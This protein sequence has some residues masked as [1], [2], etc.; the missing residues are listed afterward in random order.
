MFDLISAKR[1]HI[2]AM[3]CPASQ[4]GF[5][6]RS[7]VTIWTFGLLVLFLLA[8]GCATGPKLKPLVDSTQRF[9]GMG[10]SVLPPRG[11][12][13]FI[14][15]ASEYG[16]SFL[17]SLHS[18]DLPDRGWRT[19]SLNLLVMNP[20]H[21]TSV[22]EAHQFPTALEEL[23]TA[24]FTGG[25]FRLIEVKTRPFGDRLN[26]CSEYDFVQQEKHNPRAPEVVLAIRAHGF[27]CFDQSGEFLLNAQVS[28]RRPEGEPSEL[29][30]WM[31]ISGEEFLRNVE[32]SPLRK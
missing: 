21:L 19:L 12:G 18:G 31:E 26:F 25:R 10:F 15:L 23:M 30:A 9:D 11:D 2:E 17:R 29:M 5:E 32:I 28:E 6:D 22:E 14:S 16:V 13:W 20:E 7:F 24:R 4:R 1:D 8:P 3:L 27:I